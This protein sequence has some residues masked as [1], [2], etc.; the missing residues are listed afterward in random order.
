[1]IRTAGI[2]VPCSRRP[3]SPWPIGRR[4]ACTLLAACALALA[5]QV[6][7]ADDEAAEGRRETDIRADKVDVDFQTGVANFAGN[8]IVSDGQ[9]TVKA[10]TMIVHFSQEH[11]LTKIEARGNVVILQPEADRRATAG[12]AVYDIETGSISLTESPALRM[13]GNHWEDAT[14]ITYF[15]DSARVMSEGRSRIRFKPGGNAGGLE[16]FREGGSDD[17][18]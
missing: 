17:G 9:M 10:D 13:S 8:V 16:I 4:L 3:R 11:E 1:M 15:R 6:S 12:Y 7:G 14:K 2:E 18:T 5:G